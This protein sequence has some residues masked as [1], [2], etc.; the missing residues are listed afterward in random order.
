MQEKSSEE[1]YLSFASCNK[2]K[3]IAVLNSQNI[4]EISSSQQCAN[5][6]G[7][8]SAPLF[9]STVMFMTLMSFSI[10]HQE[11]WIHMCMNTL[12]CSWKSLI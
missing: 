4:Q 9:G 3:N 2:I 6:A 5:G 11:A 10:S 1:T 7:F 8:A 12:L